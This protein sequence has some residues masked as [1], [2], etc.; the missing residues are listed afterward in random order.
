MVRYP[1]TQ[2][3]WIGEIIMHPNLL[4][5]TPLLFRSP[6]TNL[7]AILTAESIRKEKLWKR[8]FRQYS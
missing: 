5:A 8:V 7:G 6:R 3:T 2:R 4:H 1:L